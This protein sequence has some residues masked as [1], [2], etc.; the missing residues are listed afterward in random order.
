MFSFLAFIVTPL[1]LL[2]LFGWGRAYAIIAFIFI[3]MG[4][5]F[6]SSVLG[7]GLTAAI[8]PEE[9][10]T[11][12]LPN[13]WTR[14][15]ADGIKNILQCFHLPYIFLVDLFRVY[16][17]FG[18]TMGGL[19]FWIPQFMAFYIILTLLVAMIRN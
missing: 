11:Y 13:L 15:Y 3:A 4:V 2:A 17:H 5:L 9:L 19:A 14:E 7:L 1:I 6:L 8:N 10:R 16:F 12:A 18:F